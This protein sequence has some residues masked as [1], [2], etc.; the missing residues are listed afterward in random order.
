MMI[1]NDFSPEKRKQLSDFYKAIKMAAKMLPGNNAGLQKKI[2]LQVDEILSELKK[3]S[4][5]AEKIQR[6]TDQIQNIS[7]PGTLLKK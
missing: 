5:D 7:N 1:D 3:E 2:Q 4:P 6:L